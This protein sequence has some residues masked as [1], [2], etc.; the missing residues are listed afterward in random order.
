MGRHGCLFFPMSLHPD[1]ESCLYFGKTRISLG[2]PG[3][4]VRVRMLSGV[5]AG[6][7]GGVWFN[8]GLTRNMSYPSCSRLLT[9]SAS[10]L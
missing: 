4:S 6:F 10:H 2:V 9:G 3:L 1:L 7:D 8:S 5:I